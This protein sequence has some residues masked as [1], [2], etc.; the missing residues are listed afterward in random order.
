MSPFKSQVTK[1]KPDF[2]N[3]NLA[4][5]LAGREE[6]GLEEKLKRREEEDQAAI[7]FAQNA[8][9]KFITNAAFLVRRLSVQNVKLT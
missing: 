8:V 2:T 9:I 5:V 6:A 4:E 3:P 1:W 7:A